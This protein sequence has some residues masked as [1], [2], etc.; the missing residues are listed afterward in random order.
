MPA[1]AFL[2]HLFAARMASRA[3]GVAQEALSIASHD[4]GGRKSRNQRSKV[5]LTS[6]PRK[7]RLRLFFRKRTGVTPVS[8][9]RQRS[10]AR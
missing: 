1:H 10:N 6:T 4:L 9:I 2:E 7:Y 8:V 5:E 3:S